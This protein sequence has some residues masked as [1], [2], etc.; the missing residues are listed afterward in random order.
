M[1]IAV[2]LDGQRF[3]CRVRFRRV[4]AFDRRWFGCAVIC[5]R[6]SGTCHALTVQTLGKFARLEFRCRENFGIDFVT[7]CGLAHLFG[8]GIN[9]IGLHFGNCVPLF[10]ASV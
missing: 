8:V 5:T 9:L 10:V 1:S 6:R 2:W 3:G 4:P 7:L